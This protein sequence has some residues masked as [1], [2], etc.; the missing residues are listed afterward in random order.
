MCYEAL[1]HIRSYKN[2]QIFGSVLG[3]IALILLCKAIYDTPTFLNELYNDNSSSDGIYL[4]MVYCSI[5]F[6]LIYF[7]FLLWYRAKPHLKG[8]IAYI[9][10]AS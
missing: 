3:S 1:L 2:K 10:S 7:V 9:I 5:L 8:F 6:I 4:K